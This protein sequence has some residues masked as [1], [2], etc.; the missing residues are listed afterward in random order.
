MQHEKPDVGSSFRQLKE[1][2]G[3]LMFCWCRL[4]DALEDAL[5]DATDVQ[6]RKTRGT[7][8]ERF[9]ALRTYLDRKFRDHSLLSQDLSNLSARIDRLRRK[10]NLIV[11][12]LAGV[13]A[14]AREGEPHIIHVE[15]ETDR[16]MTVKVTQTELVEL[17]DDIEQCKFEL[18]RL[19][20]L[21]RCPPPLPN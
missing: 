14:D 7:F 1:T 8:S 19:E 15:R 18:I 2:L 3:S 9:V 5:R 20:Y 17:L 21:G 16:R 10:R 11:H 12:G 6:T 4:E 13:C